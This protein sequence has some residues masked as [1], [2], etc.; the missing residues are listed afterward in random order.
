[1]P[2]WKKDATEFEISVT[3]HE[4]R[5][6]QAYLPKPIMEMLGVPKTVKFMV[7]GKRVELEAGNVKRT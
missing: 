6:F 2:K 7:K 4:L 1:M 3:S 5:G